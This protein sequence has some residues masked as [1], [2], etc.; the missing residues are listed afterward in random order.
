LAFEVQRN[1]A[2]AADARTMHADEM[3][4]SHALPYQ[5]EDVPGEYHLQGFRVQNNALCLRAFGFSRHRVV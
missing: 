4:T 3:T 5:P 1:S 2:A